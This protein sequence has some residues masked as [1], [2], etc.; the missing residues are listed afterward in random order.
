MSVIE[1]ADRRRERT[2]HRVAPAAVE[3]GYAVGSPDETGWPRIRASIR[4]ITPCGDCGQA[5]PGAHPHTN[6]PEVTNG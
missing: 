5:M 2:F 1:I 4:L 6:F 3:D